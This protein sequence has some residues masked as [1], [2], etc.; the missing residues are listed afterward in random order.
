MEREN[1]YIL[2][3]LPV[4][5]P[6]GDPAH[7]R[8]ALSRKKQEWTRM[9]DNPRKRTQALAYIALL[10]DMEQVLFDPVARK[11]EARLA[12]EVLEDMLRRFEAELRIL[13]GKGHLLPREVTAIAAKYKAYGVDQQKV[14]GLAKV[15]VSEC[16]PEREDAE[17]G[18]EVLDRLTAK[19]IRR[20]LAIVEQDDLY[21]FL[22][23]PRHST[24]KKLRDAA[25]ERRRLAAGQK[26]AKSVATGEL[27]GICLRLF[28]SSDAKQRYDRYLKISV[29][30]ALGEMVDEEFVRQKYIGEP[31][32]LRLVNYGVESCGCTVLEAEDY[33]R[34]Y[35]AAYRIPMG[36]EKA[37]LNC[38]ACKELIPCESVVC[39][40]CAAPIQGACPSCAAPFDGGPAVC[41]DCKFMLG[42]MVK[43][44]PYL[45]GA[46]ASAIDGNWSL[47]R[48]NLSFAEKYWPGHPEISQLEERVK[49]LENRYNEYVQQLSDCMAKNQHYAALELIAEAHRKNIALPQATVRQVERTIDDLESQL[50]KIAKED[51]PD[52]YL[53]ISLAET[54]SDSIEL[55]RILSAHPPEAPGP[56][57]C[58]NVGRQMHL[59][60]Q[61]SGS[62]GSIKYLLVRKQ[63][64]EPFTAFDGDVVYNGPA[65]FFI[66][67]TAHPLAEYYYKVYT[68][69][70]GTYS[71]KGQIVGLIMAVPEVEQLRIFPA[72]GGAQLTWEFNPDVRKVLIWRKL[73]GERPTAP[74]DGILLETERIDGFVDSKIKNDVEYWYYICAVYM[75]EGKRVVSKGVS[76]AITPRKI[77]APVDHLTIARSEYESE[78]VVN[79]SGMDSTDLILLGSKSEP[80]VKVGEIVALQDLL[81]EYRNIALHARGA[82]GGRFRQSFTGGLYIFAAVVFGKYA[83][84]GPPQYIANLKDVG[85]LSAELVESGLHLHMNWPAGLEEIAVAYKNDA[86]PASPDDL[87]ATTIKVTRQQY[88]YDGG[89]DLRGIAPGAYYI[90]VFALYPTGE[91]D[92]SASEGARIFYDH[93]PCQDV[94]YRIVYKKKLFRKQADLSLILSGQGHFTLPSIELVCKIGSLPLNRKDGQSL[95]V[96]DQS[97]KVKGEIEF[98]YQIDSLPQDSHLRIF[99]TSEK[100]YKKFRLMPG[101]ELK[102]T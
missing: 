17:Q 46:H 52:I 83:V 66:D 47:C 38:P 93:Q 49:G 71:A 4:D 23:E 95:T 45:E 11:N 15:P 42:D 56:L 30:P 74:E 9:Q 1:Y 100:E 65:C 89:V 99:L 43:A 28:E 51:K 90:T 20:A 14:Y 54:V 85:N 98:K 59:N 87:G 53:L 18:G 67:K 44:L 16:P 61:A 75:V 70:G 50:D 34:R 32:L 5:P 88:D 22:G 64:E 68:H 48:R 72:D 31:A 40:H 35:C 25:Q 63:G 82:E 39:G 102:I 36:E 91:D 24:I 7:I 97:P 2:L 12:S 26:T 37:T 80:G 6:A 8:A 21:L 29:Y 101:T 96:L 86:Y 57:K 55:T 62:P 76:E 27:A 92:Q 73:G 79:W 3:E 33:I 78:Y 10:P 77:I 69:R 58:E 81:A 13:E 41:H 94:F 60:W 19:T 84:V